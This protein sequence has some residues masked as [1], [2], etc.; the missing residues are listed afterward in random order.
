M[1]DNKYKFAWFSINEDIPLFFK[2][3]A[4]KFRNVKFA[5]ID[6]EDK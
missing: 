4:I 3:L 6:S 5:K 1:R 2:V